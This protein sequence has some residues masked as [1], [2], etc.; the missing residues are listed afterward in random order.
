VSLESPSLLLD[1]ALIQWK[2]D[3]VE[4]ERGIGKQE[5]NITLEDTRTH[6]LSVTVTEHQG[7]T[8]TEKVLVAASDIDLVW[9]AETLVPPLYRGRALPTTEA[10]IRAETLLT[11]QKDTSPSTHIY[12]WKVD[13]RTLQAQSGIGKNTLRYLL[14]PFEKSILL[15][16]T[17]REIDGD[18]TGQTSVR[19]TMTDPRVVLYERKPLLG[20]WTNAA[21]FS[22]TL[23]S[24]GVR[25]VAYPLFISATSL[26]DPALEFEWR[27]TQENDSAA[28][29]ETSPAEILVTNPGDFSVRVIQKKKLLQE[30]RSTGTISTQRDTPSQSVFE[31]NE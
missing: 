17:V 6:E 27:G 16:V 26:R 29:A 20:L 24:V 28:A 21:L 19:I 15:Q 18:F 9:E 5:T 12:T 1:T 23:T 25:V 4:V 14:P 2:L 11:S 8:R 7:V 3:G 30:A 13:G 10:V 22:S 31:I